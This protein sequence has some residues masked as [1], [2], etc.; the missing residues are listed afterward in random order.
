MPDM[1]PEN[2]RDTFQG[3][4]VQIQQYKDALEKTKK[5]MME[6]ERD[7]YLKINDLEKQLESIHD[8]LADFR[9]ELKNSP[10]KVSFDKET[11]LKFILSLEEQ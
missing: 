10:D 9:E 3:R 4:G 11:L 1:N 6:M 5:N 8:R 2:N 7:L